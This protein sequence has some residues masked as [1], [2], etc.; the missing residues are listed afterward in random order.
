MVYEKRLVLIVMANMCI[1]LT[2]KET[3]NSTDVSQYHFSRY[4]A[5]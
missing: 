1:E 4:R 2:E 5:N 3:R